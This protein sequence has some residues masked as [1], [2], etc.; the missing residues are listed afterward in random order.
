MKTIARSR[1]RSLSRLPLAGLCL[2]T[3][4]GRPAGAATAVSLTAGSLG[5]G[6]ELTQ[7]FSPYLD[8]RLGFHGA[9]LTQRDR[10]VADVRYDATAKARTGTAFLDWHPVASGFRLTGGLV[11]NGSRLE[12]SSLPPPGGTFRIGGLDVPSSQVGRL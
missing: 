12:G 1:R 5:G 9:S 11:Y 4:A 8:G 7:S 6:V 3:L 10:R 2:F